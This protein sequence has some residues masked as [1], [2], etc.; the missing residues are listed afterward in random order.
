MVEIFSAGGMEEMGMNLKDMLGGMFPQQ[1]K[2]RKVKVPEALE[3]LT[4]RGGRAAHR[5]WTGW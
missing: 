4:Q 3:I 2:R 5:Q 1:S